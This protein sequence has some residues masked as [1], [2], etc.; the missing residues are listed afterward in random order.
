MTNPAPD[1]QIE[2][3]LLRNGIDF[4]LVNISLIGFDPVSGRSYNQ[5]DDEWQ[6]AMRRVKERAE[7]LRW[8]DLPE[9]FRV[10]RKLSILAQRQG[11]N[12][13]R[14]DEA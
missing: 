6:D 10:A 8:W 2:D 1:A 3:I 4:D 12:G 9:R 7:R 13:V 14:V 11:L 5:C